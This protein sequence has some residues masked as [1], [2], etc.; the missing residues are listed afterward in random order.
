MEL[1]SNLALLLIAGF[2]TTT[3][4]IGNGVMAL[5]ERPEQLARLRTQPERV[6]DFIE[7][8]LRYDSPVQLTSRVALSPTI[9]NG[10]RIAPGW[11]II[12]LIGSANR[13][14]AR[15]AGAAEFDP[16]RPGNTPISFGAGAHYC[17]GAALARMEAR[18]ALPLLL[19]RLPGLVLAGEPVRRSRLVLRGY[20]TMPIGWDRP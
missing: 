12:G 9:L 13:D 4:L 18:I 6:A 2:E 14:E 7:E 16:D 15:F 19:Q 10:Q 5:L 3:N 1:L 17:L 8:I 20:E 11:G